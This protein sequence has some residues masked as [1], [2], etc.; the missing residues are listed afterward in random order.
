MFWDDPMMQPIR[1]TTAAD[2]ATYTHIIYLNVRAEVILERRRRDESRFRPEASVEHLQEWQTREQTELRQLCRDNSIL[3]APVDTDQDDKMMTRVLALLH[4][5]PIHGVRYDKNL[6][7]Q[8]L[9]DYVTT[10]SASF[11]QNVVS[12]VL[13]MDADKTLAPIDTGDRLWSLLSHAGDGA[14]N[15][16]R[17][18]LQSIFGSPL[19]YSHAAFRQVSLLYE[20]AASEQ[21][22]DAACETVADMV[23]L[24]PDFLRLIRGVL[25]KKT[26]LV[27]VL[28]CG[29]ASVWEKVMARRGLK[30]KVLVLGSTRASQDLI[31]TPAVKAHVV[32]HLRENRGKFVWAFG[33]S[34]LD[35]PMMQEA[36]MAVVV[37][38]GDDSLRSRSME[39][40]LRQILE[41][42]TLPHAY[43]ALMPRDAKPLLAGGEE[44][45][46]IDTCGDKLVSKVGASCAKFQTLTERYV[47]LLLA[48]EMRD[49][50]VSGPGLRA[51]HETAGWYVASE[52]LPSV[53]GLE[54]YTIPL[55]TQTQGTAYRLGHEAKTLIVPLM[56]GGEPMA[57]GVSKAFPRAPFVHADKPQALR[58]DLVR[59]MHAV[60]LVDSVVNTGKSILEFFQHIRGI[61]ATVR[62]VVVAGVVQQDAVVEGSPLYDSLM[63]DAAIH[64]L[65]LRLSK[66]KFTGVGTTDTGNRLFNTTFLP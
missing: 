16:T 53:L 58:P 63:S 59:R 34:P 57:F 65:A 31:V 5:F 36:H 24:Y 40:K 12:N 2:L 49:A 61:S 56:R 42:G 29:L 43:Q 28:T 14:E 48:G 44:M 9:D 13:V 6:A 8:R 60:V 27:V 52:L 50:T 15:P 22:L 45:P 18:P 17:T 20:E 32:A 10:F 41:D 25:E 4:D 62:I 33:D 30:G 3:F 64:I 1:A 21:E 47:T 54:T 38:N 66:N 23:E 55:V 46:I 37:V 35:L 19:G 39:G 7:V 26:A 51:A 11:S